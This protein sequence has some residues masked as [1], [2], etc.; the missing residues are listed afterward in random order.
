MD[1]NDFSKRYA[2]E[3]KNVLKFKG[4]IS[5]I[6][7]EKIVT[8][9]MKYIVENGAVRVG[10]I[11]MATRR[12]FYD[13]RAEVEIF[14]QLNKKIEANKKF[15]FLEKFIVENCVKILYKGN[16]LGL[17][18]EVTRLEKYL[19]EKNLKPKSAGYNVLKRQEKEI[20]SFD[21]FET[22]IYLDV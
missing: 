5:E 18:E 16:P 13:G 8:K 1:V 17:Q 7:V 11:V 3:L 21:E 14:I 22:E 4:I 20:K 19:K 9:M 6:D 15:E 2:L 10:D 12:S